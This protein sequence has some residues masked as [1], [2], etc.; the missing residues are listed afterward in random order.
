MSHKS[1]KHWEKKTKRSEATTLEAGW[2]CWGEKLL[3]KNLYEKL[4]HLKQDKGEGGVTLVCGN[5]WRVEENE[6]KSNTAIFV[7]TAVDSGQKQVF[8]CQQQQRR[9]RKT[10]GSSSSSYV[11]DSSSICEYANAFVW[12]C[13]CICSFCSIV[14]HII[15]RDKRGASS[16]L[17][18]YV[19]II[20]VCSQSNVMNFFWSVSAWVPQLYLWDTFGLNNLPQ[21]NANVKVIQNC[22]LPPCLMLPLQL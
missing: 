7:V 11:P 4:L 21:S 12:V 6:A 1:N 14:W 16:I 17:Y 10:R 5:T 19:Y 18:I 20:R 2:K 15:W 13:E 3:G 22:I 8:K 9:R